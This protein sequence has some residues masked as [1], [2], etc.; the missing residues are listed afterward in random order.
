MI[1]I[2]SV[3]DK[4]VKKHNPPFL[5]ESDEVAKRSF[6]HAMEKAPFSQDMQLYKLGSFEEDSTGAIYP[7]YQFICDCPPKVGV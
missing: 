2:Y 5:A 1:N 4:V 7:D 3:Y 6:I